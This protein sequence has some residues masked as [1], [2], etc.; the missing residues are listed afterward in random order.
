MP[1]NISDLPTD[2]HM[3]G[4]T[5][6]GFHGG[7]HPE[8]FDHTGFA[9]EDVI[10]VYAPD[11]GVVAYVEEDIRE[12]EYKVVIFHNFTIA[13][14]FDHLTDFVAEEHDEV[15]KGQLIGYTKA[16]YMFSILDWALIDFNNNTG[17]L[18][19]LYRQYKNGSFVPPFDYLSKSELEDVMQY[20][21][22]TL[23]TPF[24]NG[25]VIPH[26]NKAEHDLVNPVFPKS[27]SENDLAGVWVYQDYWE[28][29]GYPE[30]LVFIHKKTKYFGEVYHAVY[31]DYIG[32]CKFESW[33][34]NYEIDTS[35]KPYRIKI[36][37]D[38]TGPNP[39]PREVGPIY[40]IFEVSTQGNRKML[41]IELSKEGY[42]TSFSDNATI[43]LNRSRDH[44]L[45]EAKFKEGGELGI[46]TEISHAYTTVPLR[47]QMI[48]QIYIYY[49]TLSK[50]VPLREELCMICNSSNSSKG[51]QGLLPK[52]FF[53]I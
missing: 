46:S 39:P 35:T 30:I 17:P 34:A 51:K 48:K 9:A 10:P 29:G 22:Q 52:Q 23:L 25:E 15:Q 7:N 31:S 49:K 53:Y 14:W 37:F 45:N 2:P 36:T 19:T 47:E 3:G 5:T 16:E 33:E 21:N 8:G 1:V 40:G 26:M 6:W 28:R 43:Y 32:F 12:N 4:L 44:P 11:Y 18:F 41:R 20:F 42:P 38:Y 13:S 50:A 24:L 27:I